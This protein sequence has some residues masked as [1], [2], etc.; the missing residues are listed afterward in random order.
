VR[1]TSTGCICADRSIQVD[2]KIKIPIVFKRISIVF[3][4]MQT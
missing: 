3:R 1:F 4:K 2:N